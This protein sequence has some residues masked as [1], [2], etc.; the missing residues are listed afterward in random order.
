MHENRWSLVVFDLTTK[1]PVEELVTGLA[2]RATASPDGKS[3]AVMNLAELVVWDLA[4][5]KAVKQFPAKRMLNFSQGG[6]IAW[7]QDSC[8]VVAAED[9]GTA[10]VWEVV[11]P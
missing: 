8:R 5:G 1:N 3:V 2:F 11:G 6:A 10:L 7:T 4:S 9:D